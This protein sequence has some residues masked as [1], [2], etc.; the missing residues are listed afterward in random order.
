MTFKKKRNQ[1][2]NLFRDRNYILMIRQV[3]NFCILFID[4]Y[5]KQ[6]TNWSFETHFALV[7]LT[8]E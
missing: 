1:S 4:Y 7:S 3:M 8:E 5:Q 6:I 2:K